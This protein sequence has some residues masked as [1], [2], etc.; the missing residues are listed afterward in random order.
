MHEVGHNFF[1]MI[2]NSD[3]R[4]WSWMDE[5][6]NTF[7][8]KE[9][10]RVRYPALIWNAE[11]QKE[12]YLLCEGIKARCVPSCHNSDNMRRT[13][14]GPNAYTKPSAALTLLRETV[15]GPEII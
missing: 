4:Q 3:E 7:L 12:L 13:E 8:E 5:G 14:F 1:P 2:V 11:L 10:M 6:L 15:M 9:T